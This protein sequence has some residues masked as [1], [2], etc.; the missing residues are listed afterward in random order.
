MEQNL[1]NETSISESS[2]QKRSKEKINNNITA[3]NGSESEQEE[4]IIIDADQ[5]QA[6]AGQAT[7]DLDE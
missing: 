1:D 3:N 2:L 5:V 4:K 7:V 6:I